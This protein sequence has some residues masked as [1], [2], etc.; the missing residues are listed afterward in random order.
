MIN[1]VQITQH[2]QDKKDTTMV[3]I[4]FGQYFAFISEF[5]IHVYL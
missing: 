3:Y 5:S 4:E 1:Y 2:V